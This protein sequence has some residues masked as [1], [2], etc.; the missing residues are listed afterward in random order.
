MLTYKFV[1][2][3][4]CGLLLCS[5]A[6]AWTELA[7]PTASGEASY[8]YTTAVS[9]S[10]DYAV[11][12]K[13]DGDSSTT[14]DVGT[15]HVFYRSGT[16]WTEQ[17]KLTAS[18]AAG[19]DE[20]GYSVSISGDYA[21]IGAPQD[22]DTASNSGSAYVFYRSG[23]AWTEQQKLTASDAAAVD[24]FGYSVSISGSYAVVGA[25]NHDSDS[26]AAY[27][28][29]GSGSSWTQQAKLTA[30]D[31]AGDDKFGSSVS[32]SGDYAIIGA[33][34]DDDDGSNSGAAY[35]F[36]R[37]GTTWSQQQKLTASDAASS[38]KFGDSVSISGDHAIV[39]ARSDGDGSFYGSAY[40]FVRSGTT[41]S[42]QQKLTASDAASG[43]SFGKGVSISGSYAAIVAWGKNSYQGATYIF[44]A[45]GNSA[46]ALNTYYDGLSGGSTPCNACPAGTTAANIPSASGSATYCEGIAANYYG[47]AGNVAS[48]HAAVTACPSNSNSVASTT[49][50]TITACTCN[51]GYT[52]S[53]ST[54]VASTP[55]PTPAPT[56]TPTPASPTTG[57]CECNCCSTSSCTPIVVG[58]FNAGSSSACTVNA[59][60]TQFSSS[61]PASGTSGSVSSSYTASTSTTTTTT[62]G[63]PTA[64][65][66]TQ[67][68]RIQ[69]LCLSALALSV[70]LLV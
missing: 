3:L 18:D 4:L 22:D 54:C 14:V 56:P 45:I 17:Q 23:T 67:G 49:T 1:P 48:T 36:Y 46:C 42:Q 43:D 27:I 34:Q 60:R 16:T 11:I 5:G 29:F 7:K 8:D 9:I 57:D 6:A 70:T 12:G 28:F 39:G 41:W 10:G 61:C 44:G 65:S 58:S 52:L 35:V 69:A 33:P 63:S 2:L 53:G 26:G 30:S 21:I 51:T 37:S 55:T 47:T 68:H 38:D 20:F 13:F 59:C 24:W 32:I 25:L 31:A 50:T 40:V 19:D 64:A 66:G 62:S 15:A